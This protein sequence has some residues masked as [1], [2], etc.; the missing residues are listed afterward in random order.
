[1][2]ILER[3]G[4]QVPKKIKLNQMR[5][6][7]KKKFGR[8]PG[9]LTFI[10]SRPCELCVREGVRQT[11]ITEAAHVGSRGLSQRCP[12]AEA[13]PLCAR[14]H[15][16]GPGAQHVLGKRFWA[17]H[18]LDKSKLVATLQALYRAWQEDGYAEAS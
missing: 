3:D 13:I 14:H 10:R 2:P 18:R 17:H 5:S 11:T 8:D 16:E 1:V 4:L 7:T 15:R 12:D 9:Y 6:A